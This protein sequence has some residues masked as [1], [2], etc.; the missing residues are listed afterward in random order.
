MIE[1]QCMAEFVK[2]GCQQVRASSGRRAGQGRQIVCDGRS[3]KLH[4]VPWRRVDEPSVAR[5]IDVDLDYLSADA[6]QVNGVGAVTLFGSGAPVSLDL[7]LP[8]A[9]GSMSVRLTSS[10]S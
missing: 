6:L 5:G 2:D 4:I 9:V 10:G 1:P 7:P 8:S 3:V